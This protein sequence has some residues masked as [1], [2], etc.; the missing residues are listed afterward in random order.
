[1]RKETIMNTVPTLREKA[2]V[3]Q[4]ALAEEVGVTRQ[5]I[6]AIEQG[7]Y[8]PSL[9]LAMKIARLVVLLVLLVNPFDLLMPSRVTMLLLGG[10]G[11]FSLLFT[12]FIWKETAQDERENLHRLLAGRAS[13]LAGAATLLMGIIIQT[14]SHRLD[15]WL[16]IALGAMV[17]TKILTRWYSRSKY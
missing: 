13:F 17:L 12:S 4:Q 5:T 14:F 6:F 9:L 15:P 8:V 10:I 16:V 7:H 3:T 2:R 1:M 11:A